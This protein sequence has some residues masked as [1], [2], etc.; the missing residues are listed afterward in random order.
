MSF[1]PSEQQANFFNW[2]KTGNGSCV[3]EAVAGAGKTTTLINALEMMQ[4]NI[5]FGAYN[6]KIADEIKEKAPKKD[7]LF[8]GTM[9]SA[10]FG[11]WTKAA[12]RVTVDG[13]KCRSIFRDLFPEYDNRKFESPVTALVSYAKQAAVGVVTPNEESTWW[14]LIE[15]FNLDCLDYED[16]VISMAKAVLKASIDQDHKVVDFDDMIFAPLYHHAKPYTYDWVLIDEAQDT[17]AARRALALTML[18]PNGRLVAVGDRHQAIYGFTGA[19]ADALDLIGKAVDAIQMPLTVTYRCPKSIVAHANQW[20]SH[21]QAHET[22]PEGEVV[23]YKGDIIK[24]CKSGDV[25]LSRFTR[26][27]IDLVYKFIAEGIAAKVEGREIG[28]GMKTLVRRYKSKNFSVLIDRLDAYRE[29]ESAKYRAKEKDSMAAAIEDKV[30]CIRVIINRV[31]K[32]DPK[33]TTPVDAVCLEIDSIFGDDVKGCVILSTIHKS[34]GREWNNVYWLQTGASKRARMAWEKEQEKNLMYVAT[35]RAKECLYLVPLNQPE[36]KPEQEVNK[37]MATAMGQVVFGES[38][39][40]KDEPFK[41]LPEAS[42]LGIG[43]EMVKSGKRSKK[44]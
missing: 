37:E 41:Y 12:G 15:H 35:T 40:Y 20:V 18:K 33:C 19:D 24:D 8:I 27:L 13:F 23:D 2:I 43:A 5:F 32:K 42:D 1:I 25:I 26:P 4:G 38:Y 11:I 30:D 9:H 21:I 17:N 39:E 22:A 36:Q 3:L 31:Q 28:N 10:G 16:T 29:R 6:K 14:N 34:K 7:G 44:K